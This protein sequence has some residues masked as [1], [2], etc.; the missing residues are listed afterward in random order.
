[1]RIPYLS[2]MQVA[3][4]RILI[5][6]AVA[7]L[8]IFFYTQTDYFQRQMRDR[9]IVVLEQATGARIT[10]DGFH[11]SIWNRQIVL[12]GVTIRSRV[13]LQGTT[14][15]PPIFQAESVLVKMRFS[16]LFIA[17]KEL[18]RLRI[19]KPRFTVV[20]DAQGHTNVPQPTDVRDLRRSPLDPL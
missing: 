19:E 4:R 1:M 7:G 13:P 16:T 12:R 17:E 20:F 10:L 8:A 2:S 11:A 5:L 3:L 6:V 18:S 15:A 14:Q 9:V